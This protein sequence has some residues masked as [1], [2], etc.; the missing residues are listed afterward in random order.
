MS[1]S[2]RTAFVSHGARHTADRAHAARQ[3]CSDSQPIGDGNN[4][5]QV[6]DLS[7][8]RSVAQSSTILS[9]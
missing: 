4:H 1:H 5:Q 3:E 6:V 9:F 8:F 7:I 2:C